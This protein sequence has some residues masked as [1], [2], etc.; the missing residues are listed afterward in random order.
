MNYYFQDGHYAAETTNGLDIDSV[1][2]MERMDE[3]EN[4]SAREN[5]IYDQISSFS[6]ALYVLGCCEADDFLSMQDIDECYAAELLK[7]NFVEINKTDITPG[8]KISN[9][10]EKYLMVLGDPVFPKHFAIIVNMEKERPFFSKLRYFGSGY[11]TLEELIH[12]Y[13]DEGVT[14]YEDVHYFRLI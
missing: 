6:V 2:M 11:D 5:P 7:I 8:Y 12:E 3:V 1:L 10:R 4:M 14:G 13:L 9:N